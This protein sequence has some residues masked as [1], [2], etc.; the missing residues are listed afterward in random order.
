MAISFFLI[1]SWK[2]GDL[3]SWRLFFVFSLFAG[4]NDNGW[5][6]SELC[7][8]MYVLAKVFFSSWMLCRCSGVTLNM[9]PLHT[10]VWN[11]DVDIFNSQNYYLTKMG[12][13]GD[14]AGLLIFISYW[15]IWNSSRTWRLAASWWERMCQWILICEY[16]F[17]GWH[18][19]VH[20]DCLHNGPDSINCWIVD[21]LLLQDIPYFA[22]V[23][24]F[25]H[26][27]NCLL[28]N[29]YFL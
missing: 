25:G 11:T 17:D 8:K 6:N 19:A 23:F 24:W 12:C 16:I 20:P 27:Y 2:N 1:H 26:A 21:I 5:T 4:A 28:L 10:L 14:L 18:Y 15:W 29:L 9:S 7:S 3:K 13:C 22:S